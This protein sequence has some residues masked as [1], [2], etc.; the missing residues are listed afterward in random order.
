MC[1]GK[2]GG[3][4]RGGGRRNSTFAEN[5]T[6]DCLRVDVMVQMRDGRT[7]REMEG[8]KV[9]GWWGNIF[10]MLCRKAFLFGL[11]EEDYLGGKRG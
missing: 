7:G 11:G 10:Y 1:L 6:N 5:Q 3:G 4:G 2:G 9:I 8:E